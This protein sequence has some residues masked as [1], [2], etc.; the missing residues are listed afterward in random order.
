M[1]WELETRTEKKKKEKTSINRHSMSATLVQLR[2]PHQSFYR[3]IFLIYS[4][5]YSFSENSFVLEWTTFFPIIMFLSLS[6][7]PSFHNLIH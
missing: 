6:F 7:L 2:K 5:L 3:M 4:F 1:E